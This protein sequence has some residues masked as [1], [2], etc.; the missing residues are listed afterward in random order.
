MTKRKSGLPADD[1]TPSGV[2]SLCN[3][4]GGTDKRAAALAMDKVVKRAQRYDTLTLTDLASWPSQLVYET[5]P[6]RLKDHVFEYYMWQQLQANSSISREQVKQAFDSLNDHERDT[7]TEQ[8]CDKHAVIEYTLRSQVLPEYITHHVTSGSQTVH[9]Q[10]V[11]PGSSVHQRRQRV[12]QRM[13]DMQASSIVPG[14]RGQVLDFY[15]WRLDDDDTGMLYM[16]LRDLP[17]ATKSTKKGGDDE[18]DE[19]KDDDDDEDDDEAATK[20]TSKSKSALG[21]ASAYVRAMHTAVVVLQR[22][23]HPRSVLC[24]LSSAE[25]SVLVSTHGVPEDLLQGYHNSNTQRPGP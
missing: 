6:Q 18:D 13:I 15:G 10:P 4:V 25:R 20:T 5:L 3:K 12:V 23:A 7:L 9:W 1:H 8:L 19:D 22:A 17:S 21:I 2:T 24:P 16:L 14:A 11:S